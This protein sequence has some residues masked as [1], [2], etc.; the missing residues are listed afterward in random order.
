MSDL[1][2]CAHSYVANNAAESGADALIVE[3][4]DRIEALEAALRDVLAECDEA[5]TD[6]SAWVVAIQQIARAALACRETT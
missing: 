2:E 6:N 5:P 1:V 3:L 4:A